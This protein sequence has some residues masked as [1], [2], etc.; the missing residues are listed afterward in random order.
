M[1]SVCAAMVPLGP[2]TSEEN[3]RIR[4]LGPRELAMLAPL[5][6]LIVGMGVYPEPFLERINPSA[7]KVVRQLNDSSVLPEDAGVA[8]G[9]D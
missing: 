4:D 6:L 1:R 8:G 3:E 9:G 7:E 5:L 2:V